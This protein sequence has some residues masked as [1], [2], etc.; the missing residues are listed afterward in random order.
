MT[1]IDI[2]AVRPSAELRPRGHIARR[3]YPNIV[4]EQPTPSILSTALNY[5]SLYR[6]VRPVYQHVNSRGIL[7]NVYNIF[8]PSGSFQTSM[9]N[10]PTQYIPQFFMH[11]ETNHI[12]VIH[13]GNDHLIALAVSNP[14]SNY[15]LLYGREL[16]ANTDIY[17]VIPQIPIHEFTE[18]T[19]FITVRD[20]AVIESIRNIVVQVK[21]PDMNVSLDDSVKE[22]DCIICMETFSKN[23]FASFQC[24]HEYCVKC[25]KKDIRTKCAKNQAFNCPLCRANVTHIIVQTVEYYEN[26]KRYISDI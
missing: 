6:N 20:S 19:P 3:R 9:R 11:P 25:I 1:D 13:I 26:V 21:E 5:V 12:I 4:H 22:R 7:H 24:N 23:T 16:P 8:H 15:R 18:V 14:N 10:E 2:P 17:I